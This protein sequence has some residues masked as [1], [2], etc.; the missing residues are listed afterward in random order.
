MAVTQEVETAALEA[1]DAVHACGLLH[2]D[3]SLR[4]IMVVLGKEPS[5]RIL[6]FGLSCV[7]S[8]KKL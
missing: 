1:L 8:N 7:N 2:G 4:N 5:V 6:D 3:I